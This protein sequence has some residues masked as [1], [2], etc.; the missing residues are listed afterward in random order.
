MK[1]SHNVTRYKLP[2]PKND[3]DDDDIPST[4]QQE[5]LQKQLSGKTGVDLKN[6]G[7]HDW[8]KWYETTKVNN[9]IYAKTNNMYRQFDL[10]KRPVIPIVPPVIPTRSP[11][12]LYISNELSH[13]TPSLHPDTFYPISELNKFKKENAMTTINTKILEL[14]M[15]HMY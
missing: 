6:T 2:N 14:G 10:P 8:E 3:D 9:D 7:W 11:V 13:S 1:K 12:P 4:S 15:V 5:Q